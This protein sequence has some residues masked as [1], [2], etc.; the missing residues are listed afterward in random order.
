[1]DLNADR[2][3]HIKRFDSAE[4]EGATGR[5]FQRKP[6][7]I[8]KMELTYDRSPSFQ[9][10]LHAQGDDPV[11]WLLRQRGD[12]VGCGSYTVNR[13]W[14]AGERHLVSYLSDL[15]VIPSPGA[16]Q[17]WRS[18][19]PEMLADLQNSRGVTWHLTAILQD[20]RGAR[21]ALTQKNLGFQYHLA[22]ELDMVNVF[23]RLGPRHK[24]TAVRYVRDSEIER[25]FEFLQQQASKRLFG[26]DFPDEFERRMATWPGFAVDKFL[27][28]EERGKWRGVCLPWSPSPLKR[29]VVTR[30]PWF[31]SASLSM[32]KI[33]GRLAP[34]VGEPLETL[35]LTHLYEDPEGIH[36]ADLAA[37]FC[38]FLQ[39]EG[40]YKTHH[41]LSFGVQGR[42]ALQRP[43]V[44]GLLKQTTAVSIYLVTIGESGAPQLPFNSTN[45]DFEMGLV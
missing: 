44:H 30:A 42:A 27:V 7:H 11:T 22:G 16:S 33:F 3:P 20:N 41:L 13:R 10:L 31:L 14:V 28:Y 12:V 24:S 43:A 8:G 35:Y 5:L 19:Y 25:L 2:H 1:M 29:M 21:T 32:L 37:A 39:G 15:R 23:G 6:M 18:F 4:D 38:D 36:S 26:Y 9:G 17:I 45:M 40:V 34:H